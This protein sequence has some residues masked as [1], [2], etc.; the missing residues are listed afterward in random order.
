MGCVVAREVQAEGAGQLPIDGLYDLTPRLY[1]DLTR[2]CPKYNKAKL[3]R[4]CAHNYTWLR[5][6]AQ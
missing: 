5:K 4:F 1:S 6:I 3:K 2:R